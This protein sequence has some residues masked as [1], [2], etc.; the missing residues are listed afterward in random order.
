M[1]SIFTLAVTLA[2]ASCASMTGSR[3][4]YPEEK[5]T[6]TGSHIPIKEN[7]GSRANSTGDA[8]AMIRS[9]KVLGSPAGVPASAGRAN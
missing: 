2:L 6:L 5:A 3:E 8:D 7:Y 1:R 9:Q 4:D